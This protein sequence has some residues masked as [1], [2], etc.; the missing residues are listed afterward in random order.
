M[1]DTGIR[2]KDNG[3]LVVSG[4]FTL[5]DGEGNP[6]VIDKEV[7]ALCR[8][9]HSGHKPFCDGSHSTAGFSSEVRAGQIPD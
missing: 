3:P 1:A 5:E 8:C 2:V 7:V 4:T 6:I 9:G